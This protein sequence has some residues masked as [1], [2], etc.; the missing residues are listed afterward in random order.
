LALFTN[1][2]EG[3]FSE[4]RELGILGSSPLALVGGIM[5]A[6]ERMERVNPL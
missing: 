2:V 4:L 3:E 5:L 6:M 1:V